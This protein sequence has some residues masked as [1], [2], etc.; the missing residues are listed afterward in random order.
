MKSILEELWYGN[1]FPS[2]R[3]SG[4]CEEERRLMRKITEQR[5]E[6]EKSLTE[7][8]MKMLEKLEECRLELTHVSAREKFVY[9]FC[10]GARMA[11]EV[12]HFD[13]G[14][15]KAQFANK[16][17]QKKEK[18][19]WQPAIKQV[20]NAFLYGSKQPI[21]LQHCAGIDAHGA[22]HTRDGNHLVETVCAAAPLGIVRRGNAAVRSEYVGIRQTAHRARA[23]P[24]RS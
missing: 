23:R 19:R 3:G 24:S 10:L 5:A 18:E 2:E 7:Q 9:A 11:F 17:L 8:E 20:A 15:D 12:M 4:L 22:L 13:A 14:V 1:I 16:Y 21:K 6:L